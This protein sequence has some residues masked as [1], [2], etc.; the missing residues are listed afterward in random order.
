MRGWSTKEEFKRCVVYY[1]LSLMMDAWI[2]SRYIHLVCRSN[3]RP[4]VL[5]F[6]RPRTFYDPQGFTRKRIAFE[7]DGRIYK[8]RRGDR[9]RDRERE[10][11]YER[12][13][14]PGS[15]GII[16]IPNRKRDKANKTLSGR[17][18]ANRTL[19][20][21]ERRGEKGEKKRE[22][23][24]GAGTERT[25]TWNKSPHFC[26]LESFSN[27]GRNGEERMAVGEGPSVIYTS[28]RFRNY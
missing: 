28:R 3:K 5:N 6:S 11:G 10:E 18:S 8:R 1:D 27:Y 16:C 25:K 7:K 20:E 26:S 21:E 2:V 12:R 17:R 23:E 13:D 19:G 22:K 14:G 4:Q 24:R 9:T 15:Y